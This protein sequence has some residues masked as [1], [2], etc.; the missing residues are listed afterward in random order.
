MLKACE[1]LVHTKHSIWFNIG[2]VFFVFL[3]IWSG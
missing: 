1:Y 3:F 2:F